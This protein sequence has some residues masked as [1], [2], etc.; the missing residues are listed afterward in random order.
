MIKKNPQITTV[1]MANEL[2]VRI[3]KRIIKKVERIIWE[4]L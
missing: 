4:R 3:V 2:D 1:D